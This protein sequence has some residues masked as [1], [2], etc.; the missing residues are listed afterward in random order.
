MNKNMHARWIS[1]MFF[2]V[3]TFEM[4]V[5]FERSLFNFRSREEGRKNDVRSPEEGGGNNGTIEFSQVKAQGFKEGKCLRSSSSI[6]IFFQDFS[7]HRKI[8]AAINFFP[9]DF[10][11]LKAVYELVN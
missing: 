3:C 10:L 6:L 11:L 5:I 8:G 2:G 7:M 4:R 9:T 1:T